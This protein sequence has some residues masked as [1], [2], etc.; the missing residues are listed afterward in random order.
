M[1]N[2]PQA[3]VLGGCSDRGK[4]CLEQGAGHGSRL[5]TPC[6]GPGGAGAAMEPP[7]LRTMRW[8]VLVLLCLR[9]GEGMVR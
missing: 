4:G 1:I 5:Y 6:S 7:A 8:L 2:V 3:L 9:L